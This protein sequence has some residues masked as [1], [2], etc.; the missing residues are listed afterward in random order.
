M[1]RLRAGS[2]IRFLDARSQKARE[3]N[4]LQIIGSARINAVLLR[5]EPNWASDD[6]LVIY[7]T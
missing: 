5:V 4:P 3:T 6:L 1:E 7:C 2:T